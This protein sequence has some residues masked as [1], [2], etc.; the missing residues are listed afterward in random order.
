VGTTT[1]PLESYN[2]A[3]D[4]KGN[5]TQITHGGVTT[6][7]TYDEAGQ[8]TSESVD[9]VTTEFVYDVGGNIVAKGDDVF[10]YDTTWK[11]QLTSFND[12]EIGYDE[13]GNPDKT[14]NANGDVLL[15]E[16]A[17]RQLKNA[18]DVV[19]TYNADGLRTSKTVDG[20]KTEY[21]WANGT[22]VGQKS[23]DDVMNFVYDQ[24]G[25]AIG[26]VLNGVAYWYLKNLQDD[27]TEVVDA[28]GAIVASYVYDAW[29][30][31]VSQSGSLADVNP[32]RYRGYYYDVESGLYY[33]Q[34][35]YY[36]S[37]WGRWLSADSLAIADYLIVDL[38]GAKLYMYCGNNPINSTDETGEFLKELWDNTKKEIRL[39]VH[40]KNTNARKKGIDTA[41]LGALFLMMKKDHLGIYHADINC[42]QRVFGYNI[43]YD[44][45]F[46]VFTSMKS[47]KFKFRYGGINYILWAW[48]GDYINLGA[49]AELGIYYGGG[50]HWMVSKKLAM[51]MS[52]KLY[53]KMDPI[54]KYSATTWWLTGF[55]PRYQNVK[56]QQL[57]AYFRVTFNSTGIFKAFKGAWNF[58]GSGWIFDDSTISA[59]YTF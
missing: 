20:L 15:L 48:K 34:S 17:G 12:V 5:I 35:R 3:Y 9:G 36:N 51:S 47:A 8:L 46:D 1:T 43:L 27:V 40:A 7:Y 54:I 4:T 44:F 21:T 19:Y 26:F 22:L 13:I 50:S 57:T 16:W 53:Y 39:W 31:I 56:H 23:G 42:W 32:I 30:T 14:V 11:D 25:A 33:C 10:A 6:S 52:L 28:S 41:A 55:N 59:S 37:A 29:G 18:D 45:A 2:Y 58:K 24:D 38:Q 49:G